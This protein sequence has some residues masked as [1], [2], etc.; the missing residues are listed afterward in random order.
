MKPYISKTPQQ[1][2]EEGIP[3]DKLNALVNAELDIWEMVTVMQD[4]LEAGLLPMLPDRTIYL[5]RYYMDIGLVS[6]TKRAHH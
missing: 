3:E 6:N 2:I 1:N 4:T 5:C